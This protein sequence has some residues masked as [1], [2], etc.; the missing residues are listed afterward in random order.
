MDDTPVHTSDLP[1]TLRGITRAA[2][3]GLFTWGL[4]WCRAKKSDGQIPKSL[5]RDAFGGGQDDL[6][7]RL[8]RVA[9][10]VDKEDRYD[11]RNYG[12]KNDTRAAID[13]RIA[14]TKD[15]QKKFRDAKVALCVPPPQ[16]DAL[17][18][19]YADPPGDESKRVAPGVGVGAGAGAGDLSE[20]EEGHQSPREASAD[21]AQSGIHL[22]AP[23]IRDPALGPYLEAAYRD[24]LALVL[25]RP[26][27][28]LQHF[29]A[30]E[31]PRLVETAPK[32]TRGE[33]LVAYV[34]D[35]ASAFA[36]REKDSNSDKPLKVSRCV[37][38]VT[39]NRPGPRDRYGQPVE[40]GPPEKAAQTMSSRRSK[41]EE[42][43]FH[44]GFADEL[45]RRVAK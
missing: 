26:V 33:A 13:V 18:T 10:W 19:R 30:K 16:N 17:V 9:L 15:R 43:A 35:T 31:L 5:A 32:G 8:C 36:K 29:D 12:S 21:E 7:A 25:G 27:P 4:L 3:L 14:S 37:D 39:L 45:A 40:S 42:D 6:I 20:R 11:I 34:R 24:G 38:W 2:L 1:D 44:R 23:P 41:R 28:T 22:A